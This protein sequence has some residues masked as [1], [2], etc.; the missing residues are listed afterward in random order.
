MNDSFLFHTALAG[1]STSK[2]VL[3][4]CDGVYADAV[5]FFAG[6]KSEVG[7]AAASEVKA[8]GF[9]EVERLCA[10]IQYHFTNSRMM[11]CILS[12]K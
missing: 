8:D 12:L 1:A 4:L 6:G 9:S 7:G 5:K 10:Q 11:S 3:F 2:E